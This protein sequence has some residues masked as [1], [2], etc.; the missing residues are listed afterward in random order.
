MGKDQGRARDGPA[1]L[2]SLETNFLIFQNYDPIQY[3]DGYQ[4]P[5]TLNSPDK[6]SEGWVIVTQ[7]KGMP[8]CSKFYQMLSK[9]K[10][11]STI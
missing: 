7:L 5:F 4:C 10:K 2:I 3:F 8:F 9:R 11:L 1:F 6:P